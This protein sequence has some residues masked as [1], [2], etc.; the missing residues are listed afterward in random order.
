[1][2]VEDVLSEWERLGQEATEGPW[3]YELATPAMRGE[4]WHL[5]VSG[6]PGIRAVVSE[7]QHGFGNAEFIATA[8]TALPATIAGLRA[9]LDLHRPWYEVGGVRTDF[10]ALAYEVGSD[11]VCRT[12]DA[13]D[14]C[15]PEDDEHYILACA[16]CRAA[17][18][19]GTEG[20]HLWPCDTVRAIADALG[21]EP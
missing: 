13:Y 5:R 21:V 12:G 15:S 19:E 1:V 7:Y 11:H 3:A 2:S 18:E 17:T 9:V 4:N 20:Y 8:R 16:E 14:S 6:K 10:T